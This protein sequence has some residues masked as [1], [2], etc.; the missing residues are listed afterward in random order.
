MNR[1][2]I[3]ALVSLCSLL[4]LVSFCTILKISSLNK[5][6]KNYKYENSNLEHLLNNFE[7]NMQIGILFNGSSISDLFHIDNKYSHT[8]T[9]LL[10]SVFVSSSALLYI[11][12]L[13]CSS[14]VKDEVRTFVQYL[15]VSSKKL[16]F[17]IHQNDRE[18]IGTFIKS[19]G[20]GDNI[21]WLNELSNYPEIEN[22]LPAPTT[23]I[24]DANS[25]IIHIFFP[26]NLSLT[27]K[28]Y[29]Y[30]KTTTSESS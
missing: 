30:N 18:T 11:N 1:F 24:T 13:H 6:I 29:Y 25:K 3:T 15:N 5:G 16:F 26:S 27:M 17:L 10:D 21:I 20:F 23:I 7:N 4:T 8:Q 14:C 2:R 28:Q 12:Q 22:I 19:L 9:N